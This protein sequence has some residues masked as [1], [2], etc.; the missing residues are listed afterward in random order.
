[1]AYEFEEPRQV[2]KASVYWFDDSPGGGGCRVPESW[3]VKYKD[4]AGA[5]QPVMVKAPYQVHANR[6]DA[7]EFEPVKTTG[8]RL[9]AKLRPNHS[10]GILE[11]K[12]E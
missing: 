4:S 10:G 5:W 3:V 11:W 9:E 7:V 1:V 6:Y 12:V 8:L 2:S